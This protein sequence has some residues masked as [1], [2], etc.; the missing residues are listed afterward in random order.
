MDFRKMSDKELD[1]YAKISKENYQEV[2]S[3]LTNEL[4]KIN[5]SNLKLAIIALVLGAAALIMTIASL[6]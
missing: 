1:D 2:T 4:I 6:V 3:W 5:A